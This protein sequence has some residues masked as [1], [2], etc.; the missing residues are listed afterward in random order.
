METF[1]ELSQ[2]VQALIIEELHGNMKTQCT[3]HKLLIIDASELT[4]YRCW[5]PILVYLLILLQIE[6]VYTTHHVIQLLDH[7]EFN[8]VNINVLIEKW[9]PCD[10]LWIPRRK[11]RNF[12]YKQEEMKNIL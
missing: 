1:R 9:M 11:K 6:N 4:K 7:R 5:L 10:A 3:Q 2:N 12:V 8:K